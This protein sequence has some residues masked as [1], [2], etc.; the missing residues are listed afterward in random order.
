MI[1]K[2]IHLG[3]SLLASIAL[4]LPN[5]LLGQ[6]WE[7]PKH[8]E[9][10]VIPNTNAFD[11]S[12][13]GKVEINASKSTGQNL[14]LFFGA[15]NHDHQEGPSTHSSENDSIV[16]ID[17]YAEYS[18]FLGKGERQLLDFVKTS[19]KD[20]LDI[21]SAI[22]GM[23]FYRSGNLGILFQRSEI[24]SR[25][26]LD[27]HGRNLTSFNV[28]EL[29][30]RV[31]NIEGHTLHIGNIQSPLRE[32][33][34]GFYQGLVAFWTYLPSVKF[35]DHSFCDI[36]DKTLSIKIEILHD[37]SVI[38]S[39]ELPNVLLD[40]SVVIDLICEDHPGNL[41]VVGN[42]YYGYWFWEGAH[43]VIALN[44]SLMES[45]CA[46]TIEAIEICDEINVYPQGT[47]CVG[48]VRVDPACLEYSLHPL[49]IQNADRVFLILPPHRSFELYH[50]GSLDT[51]TY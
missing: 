12:F 10:I 32:F 41:D 27:I 30:V 49:E 50:K 39:A 6:E 14:S 23:R 37:D 46:K 29:S 20:V 48:S 33:R 13:T 25:F 34:R 3:A 21:L 7:W 8:G 22:S 26:V 43:A 19:C 45:M 16:I 40:S 31:K 24:E 28:S 18:R 17:R 11:A 1:S 15:L 35:G 47:N 36:F 9:W 4:V 38:G 51:H 2:H 44:K 5:I 42:E